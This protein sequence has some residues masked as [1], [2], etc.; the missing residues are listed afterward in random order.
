VRARLHPDAEPVRTVL[1]KRVDEPWIE[2]C[3][4][5]RDEGRPSAA[6][7]LDGTVL[8]TTER[9]PFDVRYLVTCDENWA[10]TEVVVTALIGT[11]LTAYAKANR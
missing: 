8:G 3:T 5:L 6:W 1:W 4:L 10:T 11:R 2:R 7:I 9:E